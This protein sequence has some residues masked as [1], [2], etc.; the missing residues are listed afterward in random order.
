MRNIIPKSKRFLLNPNYFSTEQLKENLRN[1]LT[2]VE[3][4]RKARDQAI[5]EFLRI[6]NPKPEV[7]DFRQKYLQEQELR[8]KYM[9]TDLSVFKDKLGAIDNDLPLK[10]RLIE[11][12]KLLSKL[13]NIEDLLNENDS[14]LRQEMVRD[15][16]SKLPDLQQ[17]TFYTLKDLIDKFLKYSTKTAV[18]HPGHSHI[19]QMLEI[20]LPE[21]AGEITGLSYEYQYQ[22]ENCK[23][24]SHPIYFDFEDLDYTGKEWIPVTSTDSFLLHLNHNNF[25]SNFNTINTILEKISFQNQ[26]M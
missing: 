2:S 9:I 19:A 13:D 15:I 10:N 24:T 11:I 5:L 4:Y 16:M 26:T 21:H 22:A 17:N 8:K 23:T 1:I 3:N 25:I 7:E 18:Q 6:E 12:I 14:Q 20:A